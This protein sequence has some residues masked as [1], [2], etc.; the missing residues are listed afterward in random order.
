MNGVCKFVSSALV[1][2]GMCMLILTLTVGAAGPAVAGST[3][4]FCGTAGACDRNCGGYGG[5]WL[6]GCDA[7]WGCTLCVCSGWGWCSCI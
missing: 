3:G 5:C 4:L 1:V 2:L 7:A 6:G